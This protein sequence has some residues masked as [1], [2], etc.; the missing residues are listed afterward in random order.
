MDYGADSATTLISYSTPY[1]DGAAPPEGIAVNDTFYKIDLYNS[2]LF[3]SGFTGFTG[4]VDGRVFFKFT[5]DASTALLGENTR[6]RYPRGN[7]TATVI[8]FVEH[9]E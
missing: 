3:E 8:F 4:S 1:L 7:Y 2:P 5:D 6:D 9:A